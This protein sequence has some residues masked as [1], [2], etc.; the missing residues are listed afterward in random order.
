M[1]DIHD[2][3]YHDQNEPHSQANASKA[4]TPLGSD[5]WLSSDVACSVLFFCMRRLLQSVPELIPLPLVCDES[6]EELLH[7]GDPE[8]DLSDMT[9]MAADSFG[10]DLEIVL[11]HIGRAM[12]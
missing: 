6:I 1:S 10:M 12:S 2:E 11:Q 4:M 8:V 9:R 5:P 7:C 3:Q